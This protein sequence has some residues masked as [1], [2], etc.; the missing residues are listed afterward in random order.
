MFN[1]IPQPVSILINQSEKGFTLHTGTTISP[2]PF[3]GDLINFSKKQFGKKIIMHEDTGE[4]RSI[5]L[6]LD[7]SIE[8]EEGYKIKCEKFAKNEK[9]GKKIFIIELVD[10]T[11]NYQY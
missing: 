2:Y 3:T 7:D 9:L 6:K 4:E 1:I 5:I 11:K 8:H 10:I